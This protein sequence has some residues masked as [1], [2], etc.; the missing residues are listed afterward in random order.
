MNTDQKIAIALII[1]AVI[2][3]LTV[4]AYNVYDSTIRRNAYEKCLDIN[5]QIAKANPSAYIAFC[6]R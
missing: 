1:S 5:L 3:V 6:S 4:V 2:C